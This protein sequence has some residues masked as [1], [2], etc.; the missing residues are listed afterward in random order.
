M[1]V[2]R[3]EPGSF[4]TALNHWVVSPAPALL[5]FKKLCVSTLPP[6]RRALW[7]SVNCQSPP[8]ERDVTAPLNTLKGKFWTVDGRVACNSRTLK[9]EVVGSWWVQGQPL[10]PWFST[11]LMVQPFNTVPHI[12]V[13]QTITLFPLLLPYCNFAAVVSRNIN[14]C[15]SWRS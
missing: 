11:F 3:F 12:M 13:T 15:V 1:W 8:A 9:A 5:C 7:L 2:L 10:H 6:T 14:M 4:E